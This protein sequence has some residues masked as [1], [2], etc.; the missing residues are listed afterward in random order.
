MIIFTSL[1]LLTMPPDKMCLDPSSDRDIS[2]C[3][4]LKKVKNFEIKTV[5]EI[6]F[7]TIDQMFALKKPAR[8][9]RVINHVDPLD[10][11]HAIL[12]IINASQQS[13]TCLVR[14]IQA[15]KPELEFTAEKKKEIFGRVQ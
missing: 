15:N 14:W 1:L 12:R 8:E 3:E 2:I 10:E 4:Y 5:D 6:A 11:K 7:G 9:C 13:K